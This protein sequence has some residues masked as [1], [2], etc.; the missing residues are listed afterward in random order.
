MNIKKISKNYSPRYSKIRRV[1]VN[2][3]R[4]IK[5]NSVNPLLIINPATYLMFVCFF[6][7]SI[8][9]FNGSEYSELPF[10]LSWVWLFISL[11]YF[12]IFPLTWKEM[13]DVEKVE[14]RE[15]YDLPDDWE[16]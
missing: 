16:L 7:T 12:N 9:S 3:F 4:P 1:W 14:Y 15:L 2:M 5:R 11:T 8:L 13:N 10:L 6:S